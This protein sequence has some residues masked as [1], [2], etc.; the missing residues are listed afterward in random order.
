MNSRDKDGNIVSKGVF[1]HIAQKYHEK[2]E[3]TSTD[4][5]SGHV[6]SEN[7]EGSSS[8]SSSCC[9]D[10][11]SMKVAVGSTNPVKIAAAK[12]G[13]EKAITGTLIE[14]E[15]FS[16]PSGVP[17]QPVGDE[18]TRLGATNRAIHAY[19]AYKCAHEGASPE[20][21]VGLEGGIART[22]YGMECFA[23]MVIY[24]GDK[25][26]A[27]RTCTFQ[28]P[29]AIADL[30]DGGMELGDADDRVFSTVNSKQG[31]GTVGQLTKG[32]ISRTA[33]YVDAIVLA[34]VPFNWP[35]FYPKKEDADCASFE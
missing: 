13:M 30:V 7:V 5:S 4:P 17:D 12:E 20:Y 19:E 35:Q 10:L 24:N 14:C 1:M 8:S 18:E 34:Y 22:Q 2:Y 28:L 27:A 9:H 3:S 25:F 11:K 33:Y 16:S 23:Y 6:A 32:V 29:D 31:Q 15:G 21:S 26:G